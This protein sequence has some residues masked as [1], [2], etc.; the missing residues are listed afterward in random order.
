MKALRRQFGKPIPNH[1]EGECL[2]GQGK[3]VAKSNPV[4]RGETEGDWNAWILMVTVLFSTLPPLLMA[5]FARGDLKKRLLEIPTNPTFSETENKVK[6]L[7]NILIILLLVYSVFLP[8]RLG[9]G[10]FYAGL[11]I[12]VIG[13]IARQVVIVPWVAT[14]L[15]RPVATGLYRYSRHPMYLTMITQIIGVGIASASWIFLL[16]AIALTIMINILAIPEERACLEKYGNAYR[17][18]MNRTPRWI[19][20]PKSEAK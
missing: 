18:Y 10:W 2:P 14:P 1:E 11:A 20:I 15:D 5:G 19:G 8:L 3:F 6:S 9:T 17:E 16:F 13:F 12:L 7:S 4:R